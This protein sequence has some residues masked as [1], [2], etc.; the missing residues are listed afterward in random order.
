[1]SCSLP[2]SLLDRFCFHILPKIRA[3]TECLAVEPLSIERIL[4]AGEDP[5]LRKLSLVNF[6][7][8]SALYYF[9]A[10]TFNITR[11]TSTVDGANRQ[12]NDEFRRTFLNGKYSQL[13]CCTHEEGLDL[14]LSH[15]RILWIRRFVLVTTFL[16]VRAEIIAQAFPLLTL[17]TFHNTKRQEYKRMNELEQSSATSSVAEFSHF[18]HLNFIFTHI[19]CP[20]QFLVETSTRLPPLIELIISYEALE[21]PTENFRRDATRRNCSLLECISVHQL[22]V[23]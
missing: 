16:E 7:L 10:F 11:Y 14:V 22:M 17:F 2:D 21:I 23:H 5:H 12:S 19:N 18:T 8:Q 13:A 6:D 15:V 3:N 9:S 1:M 20:E 4:Y